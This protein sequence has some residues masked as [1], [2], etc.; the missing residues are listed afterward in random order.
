MAC[1][2][3]TTSQ[4][5]V[6]DLTDESGDAF[7][8]GAATPTP[9]RIPAQ[10]QSFYNGPAPQ[11]FSGSR[12][13]SMSLFQLQKLQLAAALSKANKPVPFPRHSSEQA[14]LM[15]S[16]YQWGTQEWM[17][18][19]R[20]KMSKTVSP[21]RGA[22]AQQPQNGTTQWKSDM[23]V[24]KSKAVLTPPATPS[25]SLTPPSKQAG[26]PTP[27]GNQP[28]QNAKSRTK[29][30]A[31][32]SIKP[33]QWQKWTAKEYSALAKTLQTAFDA[34]HF[35]VQHGKSVEEVLAVFGAVV[36]RPLQDAAEANRRGTA[37][38]GSLFE[39]FSKHGTPV[40]SWA[41]GTASEGKGR[42]T[43]TERADTVVVLK[44]NGGAL[45]IPY[46]HLVKN[47]WEFLDGVLEGS[48][49]SILEHWM[50]D[51]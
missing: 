23:R 47:D 22:T 28:S 26:T 12:V 8:V 29:K 34:N 6:V 25:Q 14:Q 50:R 39:L 1:N 30:Q 21:P 42:L 19:M 17:A 16:P 33:A 31:A 15:T 7:G 46:Q 5:K 43:K 45:K 51:D 10:G 40:R 11:A 13:P 36:C 24:Q 41:V 4:I 2:V 35:G 38:M 20:A 37:G 9:S 27:T 3:P 32:F 44:E 48:D 49:R 18:D